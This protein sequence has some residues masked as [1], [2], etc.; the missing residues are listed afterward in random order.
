MVVKFTLK[1]K[2]MTRQKFILQ[3]AEDNSAEVQKALEINGKI[4]Y[5][6]GAQVR[7]VNTQNE[8]IEPFK[9]FIEDFENWIPNESEQKF[10]DSVNAEA[11][12]LK[13]EVVFIGGNG[14][15]IPSKGF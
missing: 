5:A 10:I 1:R 6:S 7:T 15:V 14:A 8:P 2:T 13:I 11:E 3:G 4:L 12:E 9:E